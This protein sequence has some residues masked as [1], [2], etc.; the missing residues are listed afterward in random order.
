VKNTEVKKQDRLDYLEE[1]KRVRNK[2]A[3][4]R[5]KIESIKARKLEEIGQLGIEESTERNLP[6]R[7][8]CEWK[9]C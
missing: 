6:R 5:M 8:L 7:R 3:E 4:D 2:L 1:G 9:V